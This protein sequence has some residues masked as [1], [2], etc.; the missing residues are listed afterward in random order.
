M[1]LHC[2]TVCLLLIILRQ[3]FHLLHGIVLLCLVYCCQ[4][5]ARKSL[6]TAVVSVSGVTTFLNNHQLLACGQF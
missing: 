1:L 5:A 2:V 3:A 4:V 6:P